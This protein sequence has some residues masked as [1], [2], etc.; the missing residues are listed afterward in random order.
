[1]CVLRA[2]VC[3]NERE[4]ENQRAKKQRGTAAGVKNSFLPRPHSRPSLSL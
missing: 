4:W 2:C 3:E 1:M